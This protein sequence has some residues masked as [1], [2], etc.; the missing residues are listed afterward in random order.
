MLTS[1]IILVS[2][3]LVSL[4]ACQT[5]KFGDLFNDSAD[6]TPAAAPEVTV[7]KETP[8]QPQQ[9]LSGLSAESKQSFSLDDES[10]AQKALEDSYTNQ[11]SQWQSVDGE[12][13]I[14]P[15]KTFEQ[16]TGNF[17][18]QYKA[19]LITKVKEIGMTSTACRQQNGLWIRQL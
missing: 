4:T 10:R 2:L 12:L 16:E 18:R 7:A 14:L 9:L 19:T 15:I 11:P 5:V 1:R 13:V 3:F 6:S 17:C 8:M